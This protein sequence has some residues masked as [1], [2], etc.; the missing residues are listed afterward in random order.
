MYKILSIDTMSN[1]NENVENKNPNVEQ[2]EGI[3]DTIKPNAEI[4]TTDDVSVK[5]LVENSRNM[6]DQNKVLQQK[7]ADLDK[8]VKLLMESEN[9]KI[10]ENIDTRVMPW[11]ES[12]DISDEDKKMFV[13]AIKD[14]LTIGRTTGVVNYEN[15]PVWSVACAAASAHGS[16]IQENKL[17][18]EKVNLME[19]RNM[20]SNA[21]LVQRTADET[22]MYTSAGNKRPIDEISASSTADSDASKCWGDV[23]SMMSSVR[24]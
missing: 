24:Q 7:N 15:N 4:S 17:L 1:E 6:M 20:K 16:I 12:L 10:K 19:Q 11:V 22:L 13:G 23:F 8:M 2:K 9:G 14:A 18:L 3:I 5:K 21:E